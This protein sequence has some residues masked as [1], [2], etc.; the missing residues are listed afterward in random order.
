MGAQKNWTIAY[1]E[2]SHPPYVAAWLNEEPSPKSD[3][4]SLG[5]TGM[6][7]PKPVTSISRVMNMK[8]TAGFRLA[9]PQGNECR[10]L[11]SGL[12]KPEVV[13][14]DR[15]TMGVSCGCNQL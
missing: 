7:I 13:R 12:W 10:P 4:T 11:V 8:K 9:I 6:M 3:N 1:D 5:I 15:W 14:Q 2:I